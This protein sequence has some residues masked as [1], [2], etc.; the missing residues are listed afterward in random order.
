LVYGEFVQVFSRQDKP[1]TIN[2]IT[3][4]WYSEI[5]Y[6]DRSDRW[7]FGG[8]LSEE[9][10][11]DLP[12]FVGMW[13]STEEIEKKGTSRLFVSFHP[14]PDNSFSLGIKETGNARSGKWIIKETNRNIITFE[15]TYK[16]D[17]FETGET[18]I[19]TGYNKITI[20][21]KDNIL[22]EDPYE[23]LIR[24]RRNKTGN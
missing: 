6:L 10:P 16:W 23:G 9:L 11:N 2:G 24:L 18:K 21:D 8:Y 13:D 4:Y 3:D 15:I 12:F 14:Y 22:Y 19:W 5:Y 1:V 20:I 17:D 7:V